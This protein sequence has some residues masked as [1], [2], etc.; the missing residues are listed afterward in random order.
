MQCATHPEV[1]TE[2][3]CSRCGKAICPRCLVYTPVGARCRE[4]ANVRRLPVY[5]VSREVVVRGVASAA[6][7][8]IAIGVAW[9][10]FNLVTY[11]LYGALAGLAIGY[12]IGEIVSL[13][14]NRR[15]GPPLQAMAVGGVL[16]A[17]AVRL[18]VLL[19]LA[20]WTLRDVRTDAFGLIAVVIA[21]FMAA[22]RLR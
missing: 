22:G 17:F 20:G 19:A 5:N 4:C 9:A 18:G 8:G 3:A 2:L 13:S 15:A 11:F 12:A 21:A 1:E 6:G 16:L 14:T 10:F 7:A